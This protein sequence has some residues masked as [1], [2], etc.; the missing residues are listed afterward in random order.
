M[1]KL[2]KIDMDKTSP[3]KRTMRLYLRKVLLHQVLA[4]NIITKNVLQEAG[5][6][7]LFCC[8]RANMLNSLMARPIASAEA[9]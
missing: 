8:A 7:Y 9:S 4:L 5:E 2:P 3:H 6:L 1:S